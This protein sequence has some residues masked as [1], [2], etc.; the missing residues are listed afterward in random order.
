MFE[1]GTR[2]VATKLKKRG[3]KR[4]GYKVKRIEG[5]LIGFDGEDRV[6]I[7]KDS[8]AFEYCRTDQIKEI[9]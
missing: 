2:I 8:G 3:A 9:G 5:T 1:K 6:I 7:K 4:G